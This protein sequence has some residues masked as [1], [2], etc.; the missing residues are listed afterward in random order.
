MIKPLIYLVISRIGLVS[1]VL[2]GLHVFVII[3]NIIIQR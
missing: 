2:T 3:C 1:L